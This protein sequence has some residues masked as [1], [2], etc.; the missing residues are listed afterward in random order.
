[1]RL[2]LQ[3][4]G[5]HRISLTCK[6]FVLFKAVTIVFKNVHKS[7]TR[8]RVGEDKIIY[9]NKFSNDRPNYVLYSICE[10]EMMALISSSLLSPPLVKCFLTCI[11]L[12]Q[13]GLC[14]VSK[15][16]ICI[17]EMD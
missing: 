15:Y 11:F 8:Y 14:S 16:N 10:G 13:V 7:R 17:K 5:N 1:M 6:V 9:K 2:L 4:D 12:F 3:L